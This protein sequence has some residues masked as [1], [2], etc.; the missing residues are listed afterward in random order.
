MDEQD[1]SILGK[2][3][4]NNLEGNEEDRSQS[5][6]QNAPEDVDESDD[7][8]GPMPAP[9]GESVTTK[10]K[11]KG[12][13]VCVNSV[14]PCLGLMYATTFSVLPHQRLYLEHLPN[15][16]QYYKS[17]MHRDVINFC[18]MTRF[19]SSFE[20]AALELVYHSS[21]QD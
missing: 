12:M 10:K 7:D 3:A 14:S 21:L 11:R 16:D 13:C 15:A 20:P 6:P 4:R 8:V 1:A 17:F 2:R 5:N 9:Q 19:E 18:T